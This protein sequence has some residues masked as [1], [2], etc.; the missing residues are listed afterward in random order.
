MQLV[1]CYACHADAQCTPALRSQER[2]LHFVTEC[3]AAGGRITVMLSRMPEVL[4]TLARLV[5]FE[6]QEQQWLPAA[7]LFTKLCAI[8]TRSNAG[9]RARAEGLGAGL[10][11]DDLVAAFPWPQASPVALTLM[12]VAMLQ[13][14]EPSRFAKNL[15]L[16][17]RMLRRIVHDPGNVRFRTLV[18]VA[19][20]PSPPSPQAA[21]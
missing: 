18:Y 4:G 5:H 11:V 13:G 3:V 9:V 6:T 14:D 8:A 17:E 15:R 20:T 2:A 10:S 19:A 21:S 12:E 1:S 16:L 7:L